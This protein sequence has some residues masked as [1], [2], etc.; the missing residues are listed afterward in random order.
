MRI[1]WLPFLS[2]AVCIQMGCPAKAPVTPAEPVVVASKEDPNLLRGRQLHQWFAE[3]KFKMIF[4]Q[5]SPAVQ[6]QLPEETW[7]TVHAQIT[8]SLG[9]ET[10]LTS[11]TVIPNGALNIYHRI[12]TRERAETSINT[13][14]TLSAEGTMEG[15]LIQP[16]PKLAETQFGDY[17]TKTDLRPP[18]TGEWFVFWG[19]RTV[20]QN[21]HAAY[22]DQRF[23]LDLL[24]KQNNTSFEGDGKQNEDYYAFSQPVVAPGPG[25][26]VA[27][28]NTVADNIPGQMNPRQPLGNHVIIDHQNGEFSLLAHFKQGTVLVKSGDTVTAGQPL[29]ECGNSGNTSESHIHYHLQNT[30]TYGKGEGLPIQFQNYSADGTPVSRGEVVKGMRIAVE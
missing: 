9:N 29:G 4:D 12:A 21:Y 15:F 7:S 8:D 18:F 5:S 28:Q 20:E 16:S 13:F 14:I 11:E 22:V 3:K 23:A 2:V 6:Q 27:S 17:Q 26:V 30:A 24:I 1:R 10:S 19:G 25:V